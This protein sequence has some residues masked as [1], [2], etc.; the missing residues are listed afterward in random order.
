M[1]IGPL[2]RLSA[3]LALASLSVLL[4]SAT[5]G[6]V[7]AAEVPEKPA[8]SDAYADGT[9]ARTRKIELDLERQYESSSKA[10]KLPSTSRSRR[11]I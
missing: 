4:A 7:L 8:G 1:L 9:A 5:V 6:T 10:D 11:P 2:T 3:R